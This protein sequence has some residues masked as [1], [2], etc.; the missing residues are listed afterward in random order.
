[1]NWRC[2]TPPTGRVIAQDVTDM[3]AEMVAKRLLVA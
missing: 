2:Y 3:L 1:M